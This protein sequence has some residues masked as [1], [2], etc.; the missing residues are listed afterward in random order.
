MNKIWFF[1]D[2]NTDGYNKLYKWANEYIEWKGYQ[3]TFWTEILANKLELPF[4]NCGK[5]GSDNYTILD[6][7]IKQIDN[8]KEGDY[9]IIGWSTITRFRLADTSEEFF[10]TAVIG[11]LP[12]LP[13]ISERTLQEILVNRDSKLFLKEVTGWMTLLNHTFKNNKIFYWSVFPEFQ[14]TKMLNNLY[15][16]YYRGKM[17]IINETKGS[18]N[19]HH[20]S[21]FGCK[22]LADIM[23]NYINNNGSTLI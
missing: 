18:I 12:D 11:Q 23:F 8:I 1:G 6:S 9:I 15:W 20:L 19:D 3:P 22:V 21:E 17:E 2:S 14:K 7:I 10:H 16:S 13:F 5:G 4:E